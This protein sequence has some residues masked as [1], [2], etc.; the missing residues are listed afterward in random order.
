MLFFGLLTIH[1]YSQEQTNIFQMVKVPDSI[2]T[3]LENAYSTQRTNAG[4]NVYN[5]LQRNKFDFGNGIYSFQGQGPHFP[6]R[7]FIFHNDKMFIFENEGAFYPKAVLQEFNNA[8]KFLDLDNE[9]FITYLEAITLYLR[10]EFGNTYG[11]EIIRT[12]T[13]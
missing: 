10:Q 9:D 11:R 2:A 6:R 8:A 13:H 12:K 7:L 1:S 4:R 5:L 3:R